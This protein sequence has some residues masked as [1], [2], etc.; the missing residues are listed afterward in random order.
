[1]AVSISLH[2][3]CHV[4]PHVSSLLS[5]Y[6]PGCSMCHLSNASCMLCRRWASSLSRLRYLCSV[7]ACLMLSM[8][9]RF[10]DDRWL[11]PRPVKEGEHLGPVDITVTA[12][13]T[14]DTRRM[15]FRCNHFAHQPIHRVQSALSTVNSQD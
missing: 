7:A 2:S 1:M 12:G 14:D 6:E 8:V 5:L 13:S 9:A 4:P 3:N 11:E 10:S 15:A